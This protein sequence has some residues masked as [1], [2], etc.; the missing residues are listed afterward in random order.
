M[1]DSNSKSWKHKAAL[2]LL[3]N[4]I[5]NLQTLEEIKTNH[6]YLIWTMDSEQAFLWMEL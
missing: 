6:N 3:E 5:P 2:V 4:F 1:S